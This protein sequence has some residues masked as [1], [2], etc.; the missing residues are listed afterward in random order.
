MSKIETIVSEISNDPHNWAQ[1]KI[2][3]VKRIRLGCQSNGL[4][5]RRMVLGAILNEVDGD[6][7]NV[8]GQGFD[9]STPETLKNARQD[10]ITLLSAEAEPTE[11]PKNLR[12]Q[13]LKTLHFIKKRDWTIETEFSASQQ[14]WELHVLQFVRKRI[15][16]SNYDT[17]LR[18]YDHN[19]GKY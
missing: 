17:A 2:E 18:Y 16:Q 9:Y 6:D 14:F 15:K 10:L 8:F 19:R 11:I 1:Q 3:Y 13:L 12:D 4:D 5:P 7:I